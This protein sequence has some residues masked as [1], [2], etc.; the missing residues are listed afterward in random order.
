MNKSKLLITNSGLT[1]YE[2]VLHGLPVVV[3]SD[4]KESQKI[5]KVFIKK[6]KQVYF[7]YLKKEKIDSL[8]L[9]NALQKQLKFKLF[10]KAVNKSYINKIKIF[11]KK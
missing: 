11:F 1:K 10:D 7:S 5:D 3:F 4:S 8:K 6:T 9:K 2:G